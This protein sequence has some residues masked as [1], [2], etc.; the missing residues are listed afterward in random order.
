MIQGD[1]NHFLFIGKSRKIGNTMM[2]IHY[3]PR[4]SMASLNTKRI[5]IEE[6]FIK[7]LSPE[8]LKQNAWVFI[9]L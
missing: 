9:S 8:M 2:V 7:E 3:G 1:R 5:K 4:G 6:R